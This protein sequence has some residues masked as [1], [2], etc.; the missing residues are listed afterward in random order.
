MLMLF[1]LF[2]EMRHFFPSI[3]SVIQFDM[4]EGRERN[5][6]KFK[7]RGLFSGEGLL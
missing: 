7:D 4:R 6:I 2:W 3:L 5:R 1:S